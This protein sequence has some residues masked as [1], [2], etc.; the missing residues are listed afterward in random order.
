[1]WRKFFQRFISSDCYYYNSCLSLIG[2][3]RHCFIQG[4]YAFTMRM[5]HTGSLRQFDL[6][7]QPLMID[8]RVLLWFKKIKIKIKNPE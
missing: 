3:L 1:M 2:L 6:A 5:P 7:G 4:C 8:Y